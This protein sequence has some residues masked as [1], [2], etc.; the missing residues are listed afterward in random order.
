MVE[1]I[2]YS[3]F[4]GTYKS[5]NKCDKGKRTFH[6]T[7][8]TLSAHEISKMMAHTKILIEYEVKSLLLE[9]GS[10][11]RRVTG[12]VKTLRLFKLVGQEDKK[13]LE[14]RGPSLWICFCVIVWQ[15]YLCCY[16]FFLLVYA[17]FL[18]NF[19]DQSQY[20]MLITEMERSNNM[21]KRC[22]SKSPVKESP[23]PKPWG[24]THGKRAVQTLDVPNGSHRH[25]KVIVHNR[26]DNNHT[27]VLYTGPQQS[28]IGMGGMVDY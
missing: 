14:D 12:E 22:G 7:A 28:M 16:L 3:L 19:Q 20:I 23:N 1:Q 26:A 24:F 10:K 13:I 21:D 25:V 11:N 27:S 9:K 18:L 8:V 2:E 6:D 17:L 15:M 4:S 5:I